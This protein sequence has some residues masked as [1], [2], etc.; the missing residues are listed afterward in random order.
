MTHSD[1]YLELLLYQ[2]MK[3]IS[4]I[5]YCII[6]SLKGEERRGKREGEGEGGAITSTR[7]RALSTG[8]EIV[9]EVLIR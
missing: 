9:F 5:L 1:R 3:Y 7:A 8:K 2:P 4:Y 6:V